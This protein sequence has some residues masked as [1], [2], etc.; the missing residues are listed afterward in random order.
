MY[1]YFFWE[2]GGNPNNC[3]L[4]FLAYGNPPKCK[5]HVFAP[6]PP[7]RDDD[8]NGIYIYIFNTKD[9]GVTLTNLA[10]YGGH[11]LFFSPKGAG[12]TLPG[13]PGRPGGQAAEAREKEGLGAALCW[14]SATAALL[15]RDNA[16]QQARSRRVVGERAQFYPVF[17][18][19]SLM[20]GSFEWE[21]F[22]SEMVIFIFGDF[23]GVSS[24]KG[25]FSQENEDLSANLK[26]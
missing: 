5:L 21:M 23:G 3:N 6:P 1:F 9:I 2:G 18:G 14:A 20:N 10:N 17:I 8:V 24:G 15:R 7:C 12:T 13:A 25:P 4:L 26:R 16:Q 22:I 19:K 11:R